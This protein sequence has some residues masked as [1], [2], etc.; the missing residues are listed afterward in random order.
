MI[1][2]ECEYTIAIYNHIHKNVM[3]WIHQSTPAGLSPHIFV[4]KVGFCVCVCMC[5]T[6]TH[7]FLHA[8]P[9]LKLTASLPLNI[10]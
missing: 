8:L 1:P 6:H 10:G 3:N 2:R 5:V 9:S 7:C 4:A